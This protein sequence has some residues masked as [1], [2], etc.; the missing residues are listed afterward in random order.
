MKKAL[1]FAFGLLICLSV[2]SQT[3]SYN[4]SYGGVTRDFLVHVPAGYTPGQHLPLV[5]NIHGYG[6][7]AQLEEY[8]SMMDNTSDANNFIVVYPDGIA[9]AWN[10]GWVGNYHSGIDDVGFISKLIDT[11]SLLYTVDLN[12]VYA[13]GLS[14]GGFLSHRLAC[15]LG[16]RIAA[17]ASV[18]GE[19]SDSV[20]YYCNPS[21][22]IPVMMI[23]GTVDPTV[24]Y[25]NGFGIGTEESI[26][27]WLNKNQCSAVNDT[28][29]LPDTNIT[30]TATAQRINYRSC[31]GS[32]EVLF[33]KIINGGHTWPNALI[34]TNYGPTCRDFDAS[35]EIWN[36]FN[37]Y[38][39]TGPLGITEPVQSQAEVKVYPN[40]FN[41]LVNIE[42]PF[43]VT[44]A[45]VCNTLGQTVIVTENPSG[46]YALNLQLVKPGVYFLKLEGSNSLHT[47][48]L[49]KGQ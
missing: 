44:R 24:P 43:A 34:N 38:T 35:A 36:F 21:R 18:A 6:M 27:I 5:F 11:M 19:F 22:K 8:Y 10:V 17:I 3:P 41:N 9:N 15:E 42:A 39:L 32:T 25:S 33:Y 23:H 12:R 29:N 49:Y 47:Q 40:P 48:I 45:E 13:C 26:A 14:N 30:D 7:T 28:I 1:P 46:I 4:I 37:R 16:N 31:A 20:A 2:F